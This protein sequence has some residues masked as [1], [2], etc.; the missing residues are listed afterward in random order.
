[1]LRRMYRAIMAGTKKYRGE[2]MI[3]KKWLLI[4]LSARARARFFPS[5]FLSLSLFFL[6][7][8]ARKSCP[9]RI[10]ASIKS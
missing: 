4:S 3:G 2:K 9:A 5:V 6:A 7:E 8:S 10:G 1:M